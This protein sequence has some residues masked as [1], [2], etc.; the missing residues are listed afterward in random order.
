M[1]KSHVKKSSGSDELKPGFWRDVGAVGSDRIS[2]TI[3]YSSSIY[4]PGL[5]YCD[6]IIMYKRVRQQSV[7]LITLLGIRET[8]TFKESSPKRHLARDKYP[9]KELG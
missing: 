9:F 4:K 3:T 1:H 6:P 5:L 8:Q 2:R 7:I